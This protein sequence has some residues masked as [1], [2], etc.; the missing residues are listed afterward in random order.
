MN[1]PITTPLQALPTPLQDVA[2]QII[3]HRQCGTDLYVLDLQPLQP[4]WFAPG[5]FVMLA[6]PSDRFMFRRPFSVMSQDPDTGAFALYYKA[7]GLGT[8]LMVAHWS[9][10]Q[11]VQVLAPLGNGFI[12]TTEPTLLIGGGIG[13]APM[14]FAGQASPNTFCVFGARHKQELGVLPELTQVF[15]SDRLAVATDDGSHGFAGHV[16][17][18]LATLPHQVA[19]ARHAFVCGPTPMMRAV[20]QQLRQANPALTVWVSLEEHMP[21]GI[22]AC[23]GCVVARTQQRL[24]VK[25]CIDG[26]V[27]N[28]DD[29]D[30][31]GTCWPA[32]STVGCTPPKPPEV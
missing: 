6:M 32:A 8:R 20:S 26:P 15:G 30:W 27:L 5:Q 9:I 4:V 2:C 22:G 23:T 7:V 12:P 18:L 19:Q 24:P 13:I 21:C 25:T 31:A 3:S 17:Q 1:I 14:V 16:G 10:G 28:A 29:V 11:M